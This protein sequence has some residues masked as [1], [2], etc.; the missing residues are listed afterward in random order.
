M[1]LQTIN[2]NKA[3]LQLSW[4]CSYKM[5]WYNILYASRAMLSTFQNPEVLV[6]DPGAGSQSVNP[7]NNPEEKSM[8]VLR[9]ASKF[10]DN[11]NIS[12]RFHTN[13]SNVVINIPK[14]LGLPNDYESLAKEVGPF[15]D[16]IELRM[17]SAK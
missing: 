13:T 7:A 1:V 12:I 4:Q 10:F 3:W 11:K 5:Q 16:S 6:G 9:G 8:L 14:S 15:M 2:E 17:Y